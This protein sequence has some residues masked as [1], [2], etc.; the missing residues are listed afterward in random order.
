[1]RQVIADPDASGYAALQGG[2]GVYVMEDGSSPEELK[3]ALANAEQQKMALQHLLARASDQIEELVETDC[4]PE[5]KE[6]A[7]QAAERFRRAAQL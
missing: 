7:T 1:L 4:H 5:T 6:E 3:H 2:R